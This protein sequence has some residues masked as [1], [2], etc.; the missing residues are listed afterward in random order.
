M[1]PMAINLILNIVAYWILI[2]MM[3]YVCSA[4][5]VL[6]KKTVWICTGMNIPVFLLFQ[7]YAEI[8]VPLL[9]A[10]TVLLF[11]N[12]KLKD[13]LLFFPA[14]TIY[15]ILT[16]IPESMVDVLIPEAK[17]RVLVGGY[18]LSIVGC[19]VDIILMSLLILLRHV[20]LKYE[21][22]VRLSK[23]EIFSCIGVF[24]FSMI[25]GAFLLAANYSAMRPGYRYIWK[26]IF[27]GAFIFCV[28]AF[29]F[30]L[31]ES[32]VRIYRKTLSRSE[33]EYLRIQ[34]DSLQDIKENE[35]QVKQLRHDLSNH[36]TIIQSL[37]DDGNYDEIRKY[38]EHLRDD[39]VLPGSDVLT[40]NR[41]ADLVVRSKLK[42][43][44]EHGIDFTFHGSLANL[45]FMDAPDICGLLANAYDN[46]IE[47]C[48]PQEN[49]YICTNVSSTRNYTVIQ[50]TNSVTGKISVRGNH[51]STTKKDKSSHGY[52]IDIMKRIAHKYNGSCTLSSS[53]SEFFVKIVLLVTPTHE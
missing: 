18:P 32:R 20:L 49:P 21:I 4:H 3:Q 24:F 31:I 29:L 46:A 19:I 6:T 23:K 2:L 35:E 10:A 9:V 39:I 14:F 27:I 5:M 34:L 12:R 40:G 1:L 52:G 50:I 22:R 38:T 26:I 25:D 8:C 47:A 33:T 30:S 41:V 7:N 13:L 45:Q 37:C 44:K 48:L 28:G 43:A 42:I 16:I 17:T 53:D 51:I 36:L 11:S 15:L